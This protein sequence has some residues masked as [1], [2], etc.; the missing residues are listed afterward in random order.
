MEAE[1]MGIPVLNSMHAFALSVMAAA[2]SGDSPSGLPQQHAPAH[3][4]WQ[5]AAGIT[6]THLCRSSSAALC[7]IV[8]G[9]WAALHKDASWRLH[10]AWLKSGKCVMQGVNCGA[11]IKAEVCSQASHA[12]GKRSLRGDS[13]PGTQAAL[14]AG[15][16]VLQAAVQRDASAPPGCLLRFTL[17]AHMHAG[18]AL[19]QQSSQLLHCSLPICLHTSHDKDC[20]ILHHLLY[21]V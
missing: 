15:A 16:E 18:A 7:I 14:E 6:T 20:Q 4:R 21:A 2:A 10:R 17:L 3:R 11:C 8:L 5:V 13:Q 9:N 1:P 19:L 12:P